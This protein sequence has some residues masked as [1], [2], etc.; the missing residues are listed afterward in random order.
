[1][2]ISMFWKLTCLGDT[3]LKRRI[4]DLPHCPERIYKV[5]EPSLIGKLVEF[6]ITID[7]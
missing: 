7:V 5:G 1:M 2:E 6:Q 4:G 3:V